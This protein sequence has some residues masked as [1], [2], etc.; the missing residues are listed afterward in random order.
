MAQRTRASCASCARVSARS[1][2]ALHLNRPFAPASVSQ[3]PHIVHAV[4]CPSTFLPPSS[5]Y[6]S[7]YVISVLP[8]QT[9]MHLPEMTSLTNAP[10]HAA[11]F[12]PCS[13]TCCH[14]AVAT[15]PATFITA[16]VMTSATAVVMHACHMA[17]LNKRRRC[18]LLPHRSL[19]PPSS[20]SCR[21]PSLH[22]LQHYESVVSVFCSKRLSATSTC[23]VPH[24]LRLWPL[25][26]I[27]QMGRES[28]PSLPRIT[29]RCE[30][31]EGILSSPV[32][33]LSP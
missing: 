13:S 9:C 15:A 8:A 14:V 33:I 28:A 27:L 3:T 16:I 22:D 4:S 1:S 17:P 31:L 21:T 6:V 32:F 5:L 2:L 18:V 10:T 12:G 30:S 23:L 20:Q 7:S 11:A 26:Y 25:Y 19:H 29:S 24:L